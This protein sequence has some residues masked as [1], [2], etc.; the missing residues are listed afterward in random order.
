MQVWNL[1]ANLR[2]CLEVSR[3]GLLLPV[4]VNLKCFESAG[5]LVL[6]NACGPCIGQWDRK[7]VKHGEPNTSTYFVLKASTI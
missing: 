1:K 6:A 4:M 7:D 2:L 3:L 5:G